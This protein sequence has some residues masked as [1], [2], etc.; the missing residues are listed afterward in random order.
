MK[1]AGKLVAQTGAGEAAHLRE[2]VMR[3]RQG[4]PL[5]TMRG[6]RRRLS[7]AA[8]PALPAA[9]QLLAPLALAL[10]LAGG[11]AGQEAPPSEGEVLAVEAA[12]RC[13]VKFN[14]TGY[15][16]AVSFLDPER[17]EA[18]TDRP[19]R[20][21]ST[22]QAQVFAEDFAA[23]FAGDPPN[24]KI[25]GW[26]KKRRGG[27]KRAHTVVTVTTVVWD[28]AAKVLRYDVEQFPG[29]AGVT[30]GFR[31]GAGAGEAGGA[32]ALRFC[33]GFVDSSFVGSD[34]GNF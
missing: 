6:R 33:S 26:R 29:Q 32:E 20:L 24:V 10:L 27:W 8:A 7:A 1:V 18:F 12:A 5:Q 2:G 13:R 16:K 28:A 21:A 25:T 34:R 30:K 19:A 14:A 22:A 4:Q 11:A 31:S 15:P 23:A 9:L 3:A 17:T